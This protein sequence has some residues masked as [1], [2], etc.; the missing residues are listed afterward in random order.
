MIKKDPI[1]RYPDLSQL[2]R[3][4][5]RIEG[6]LDCFARTAV[7]CDNPGCQWYIYCSKELKKKKKS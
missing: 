2:I 1:R 5:Q 4:I 6:K 3:S 7:G